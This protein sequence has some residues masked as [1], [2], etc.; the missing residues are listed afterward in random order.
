MENGKIKIWRDY[1]DMATYTK[2]LDA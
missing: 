1:F 2:A